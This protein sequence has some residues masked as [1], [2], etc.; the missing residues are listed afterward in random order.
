MSKALSSVGEAIG[1]QSVATKW[2]GVAL[3]A[4][5]DLQVLDSQQSERHLSQS[6]LRQGD[7]SMLRQTSREADRSHGA[8]NLRQES[9]KVLTSL[10]L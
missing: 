9:S 8:G 10:R 1:S 6:C 3:S 2:R 4:G 7:V 5:A